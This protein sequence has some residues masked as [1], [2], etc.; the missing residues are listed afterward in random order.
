[1]NLSRRRFLKQTFGFSAA[2]LLS[3]KAGPLLAAGAGV[4][5]PDS[6]ACHML[7]VGDY[8]VVERDLK[9]QKAVADAMTRYV[10]AG[11]LKPDALALL[12]DNFYGGLA[13][14]G[15]NSPRWDMNV[16][17]MYPASTFGCP[18][19]AMLGNHDYSDEKDDRSAAAQLAYREHAPNSRWT[20]PAKWY[21]FDLPGQVPLASF[22]VL[23]TNWADNGKDYLSAEDRGKQADWVAQEIARPRT[24]PWLFVLGHHP[25][26]ND[27]KHGDTKG[28]VA[29]L[30]PLLRKNK[31]DLYLCGHDHDLQHLEFD[32]HPTSFVVSGAGGARSYELAATERR[33][34]GKSVYGFSHLEIQKDRFIVRHIDANGTLLYAFTKTR[35]GRV[36]AG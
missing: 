28:L 34:F 27:G 3:G 10:T 4:G 21:R 17:Q 7:A 6:Q 12:G 29:E 20:M 16:E 18:M 31:V 26:F 5:P 2:A 1:M 8:G 33:R 30:D 32:G 19:Y 36:T 23:D 15:V 24:A 9:R 11:K 22:I 35:D 13:G 25:V 14:K